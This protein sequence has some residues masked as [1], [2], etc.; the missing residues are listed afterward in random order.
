MAAVATAPSSPNPIMA[1]PPNSSSNSSNS[2]RRSLLRL[3]A[4]ALIDVEGTPQP[5]S[6][7]TALPLAA[8][9]VWFAAAVW[10]LPPSRVVL[11]MRISVAAVLCSSAA[12]A[13]AE[14]A[15]PRPNPAA[16][17]RRSL[18]AATTVAQMATAMVAGPAPPTR[19]FRWSAAAG[20]AAA[21]ALPTTHTNQTLAAAATRSLPRSPQPQRGRAAAPIAVAAAV[22]R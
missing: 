1:P 20:T 12:A 3:S 7:M 9:A 16:A 18:T 10:Q 2:G 19:P 13:E 22:R 17:H 21:L 5:P 8:A 6:E 11:P 15:A 14:G 4:T